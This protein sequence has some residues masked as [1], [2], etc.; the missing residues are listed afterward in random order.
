M[1]AGLFISFALPFLMNQLSGNLAESIQVG[2]FD[3]SPLSN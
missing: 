2:T 3:F 1:I